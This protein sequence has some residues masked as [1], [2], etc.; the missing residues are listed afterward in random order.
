MKECKSKPEVKHQAI[1][2]HSGGWKYR[3]CLIQIEI[4]GDGNNFYLQKVPA[5]IKRGC[6]EALPEFD[7]WELAIKWIDEMLSTKASA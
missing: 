1:R 3:S 4:T 2:T 7:D 6:G 5:T